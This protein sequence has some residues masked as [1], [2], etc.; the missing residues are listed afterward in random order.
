MGRHE[1]RDDSEQRENDKVGQSGKDDEKDISQ[2]SV[3]DD[4][5]TSTTPHPEDYK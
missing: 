4:K 2:H 5:K 3:E 1:R